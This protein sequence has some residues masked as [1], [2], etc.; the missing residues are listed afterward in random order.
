MDD[1]KVAVHIFLVVLALGTGWRLTT[2]HLLAS[3][4]TQLKH[5]GAGMAIQY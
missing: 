2:Y 3:S 4:N 1:L 5:L